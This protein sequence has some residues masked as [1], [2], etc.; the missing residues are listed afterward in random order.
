MRLK[1]KFLQPESIHLTLKFLGNIHQERVL[2]IT[3]VLGHIALKKAPF[4]L[5][6]RGCGVFT[7]SNM[8]RVIWVGIRPSSSLSNM[9]EAIEE[10]LVDKGFSSEKRK[11]SPH[12]T[13][14]RLTSRNNFEEL[15]NFLRTKTARK[16][17]GSM[18][19]ESVHVYQSILK[20]G[21]AKYKQLATV[22]LRNGT[23]MD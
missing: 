14:A 6:I 17:L 21:G 16:D 4:L 10:H 19:V 13:L 3:E 22:R 8:A 15:L 1:G 11:Y 23:R 20:S 9:Q 12:L 7:H 18:W 5:H 2:E